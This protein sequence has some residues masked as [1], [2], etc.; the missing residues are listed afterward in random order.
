MTTPLFLKGLFPSLGFKRYAL[1]T[2]C[3]LS[4]LYTYSFFSHTPL[5]TDFEHLVGHRHILE[6]GS[7]QGK[8]SQVTWRVGDENILKVWLLAAGAVQCSQVT[9]RGEG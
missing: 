8:S 3:I 5:S 4:S 2:F 7:W 6:A 1:H 9:C